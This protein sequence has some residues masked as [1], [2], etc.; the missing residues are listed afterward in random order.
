MKIDPVQKAIA[1]LG[2]FPGIGQRTA[3][4]MIF[5]L[6]Q[7]DPQIA[8]NIGTALCE[9]PDKIKKCSR[10]FTIS[11]EQLCPICAN[12]NRSNQLICV[13]ERPQDIAKIPGLADT[14]LDFWRIDAKIPSGIEGRESQPIDIDKWD[15]IDLRI[16]VVHHFSTHP[17]LSGT[18]FPKPTQ[19][20]CLTMNKRIP[21]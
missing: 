5:W 18:A 8:V 19:F 3:T 7:Q 10:C 2:R 21:T 9:L 17:F 1:Q 14:L 6:M 15:N 12:P 13:V 11:T 20:R 4:R 16:G